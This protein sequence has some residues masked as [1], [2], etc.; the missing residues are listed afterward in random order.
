MSRTLTL[1]DCLNHPL[2]EVGGKAK[3]LASAISFGMRVPRGIVIPSASVA[4]GITDELVDAILEATQEWRDASLAV[5]SSGIA[6]DGGEHSFAGQFATVL[7]VR[8]RDALAEALRACRDSASSAQV[9]A[10]GHAGAQPIAIIVQRQ[11]NALC[12]GVAFSANP[13]TGA[14]AEVVINAVAGLGDKLVSGEAT[15]EALV[16]NDGK[17]DHKTNGKAILSD[18]QAKEI[19]AAVRQLEAHFSAPQDVEWAIDVTGLHI[20][21]SRPIT[22]LP[23]EPIHIA[24]DIPPGTWTRNDHH[25]TLS[26]MAFG[27]FCADYDAAQTEAMR[28]YA[29]P[30]KT[31]Q[32]R[33]IGGHLYTQ[34][35][36]EGGDQKGTPPN[37]VMWLVARLLPMMRR[38]TK[39]AEG[40][41]R[42]KPHHAEMRA[43]EEKW[44]PYFQEHNAR[45]DPDSLSALDDD[46]LL[47][48]YHALVAHL[49]LGLRV[50][51]ETMGNWIAICEF[52][53]FCQDHLGWDIATTLRA[54]GGWSKATTAVHDELTALCRAHFNTA[55]AKAAVAVMTHDPKAAIATKP[56]F[57]SA[58]DAWKHANR[59]R[60]QHYDLHNPT[61]GETPG[62]VER[63][64]RDILSGIAEGRPDRSEA[65]DAE[66]EELHAGA[67]KK[68]AGTPLLVELE[69]LAT[70]AKRAYSYRDENGFH[71]IA[72]V[73]GIL[74]LHLLEMGR[75]MRGLGEPRHLFYLKPEE[76]E[77]AFRGE[78]PDM[79][80]RIQRRLGEEQWAKFNRGPRVYGPPEAPM[81][82]TDPLPPPLRKLFRLFDWMIKAEM[83]APSETDRVEGTLIGQPA[84]AGSYTGTARVIAGPQ[85][86]HRV[87]PGDVLVCRIT[88]GE[89]SMVF[90][91]VGALVTDEG[92]MLSH[93]AIIAREFGI[94][95]VVNTDSATLRIA[96]G[97]TVTVDG[98]N[99]MVRIHP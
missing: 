11:V 62:L 78:L 93:P 41:F 40:I 99:G 5:R 12:A 69:Q 65:V 52:G 28:K 48:G 7:N 81:P 84:S 33:M 72:T 24:L 47:A 56:P 63:Q 42:D 46:E 17:V 36:M 21:Q 94:P 29:M 6:E 76:L 96:D 58:L 60:I 80:A 35:A 43:W 22:A 25:T 77:P 44:K 15:P 66:R 67:R 57:R 55:E 54:M 2:G 83:T 3:H 50:H 70:W 88:S 85:D 79:N 16:V 49:K 20:L 18:A 71:T 38:M 39:Q 19:G 87:R 68:L 59:L 30:V 8:G 32:S 92:G 26:P 51:A 74:R 45:F 86:F 13:V 64:L 4:V 23:P 75:R 73:F 95:A 14:R 82:P 90:G 98:G 91:R 1:E 34:F 53:L 97:G 10:Y 89:W 61:L 31:I 27:L 9:K 37:W